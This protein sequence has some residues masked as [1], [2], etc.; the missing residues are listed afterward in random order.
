MDRREEAGRVGRSPG[1]ILP[2]PPLE[3]CILV[4][5]LPY[6]CTWAALLEF[7]STNVSSKTF[8]M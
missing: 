1:Q 4:K 2:G 5:S 3:L 8:S 6:S 7:N